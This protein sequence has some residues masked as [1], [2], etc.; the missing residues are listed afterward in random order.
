MNVAD[1]E[2]LDL[3]LERMG[4]DRVDQIETAD[5]VIVN[6]C[7]VRQSAEDTA[8]GLLGRLGKG[9]ESNPDRVIAVMGCM[10]VS[11]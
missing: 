5:V 8:T 3:S 10:V 7:V 11:T 9:Q 6:T 1:S 4:L 2:R